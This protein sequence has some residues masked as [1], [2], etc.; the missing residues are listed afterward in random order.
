MK[1]HLHRNSFLCLTNATS[2]QREPPTQQVYNLPTVNEIILPKTGE[3]SP[4]DVNMTGKVYFLQEVRSNKFFLII[5]Y[6]TS[7]PNHYLR[8]TALEET[9][10]LPKM[11][12]QLFQ[13]NCQRRHPY[14]AVVFVFLKIKRT[15]QLSF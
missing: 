14:R 12:Y 9:L 3:Q 5:R 13:I 10:F 6:K 4:Q 1:I 7:C 11:I 2:V 15:N 8:L